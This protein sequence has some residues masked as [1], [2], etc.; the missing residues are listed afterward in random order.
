MNVQEAFMWGV[1]KD[2]AYKETN[3]KLKLAALCVFRDKIDAQPDN[4]FRHD[5]LDAE[6]KKLEIEC[7]E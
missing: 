6:I 3:P 5:E 1:F 7:Q 2:M 4:P